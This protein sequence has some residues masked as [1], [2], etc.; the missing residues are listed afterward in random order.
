MLRQRMRARSFPVARV[1]ADTLVVVFALGLVWGGAMLV[2]LACKAA[3]GTIDS[4]SGYRTAY[5]YLASLQPS[6]ITP[7]TREVS[8]VAGA[9]AAVI[10]GCLA[11]RAIPRPYL[12]RGD[13]RLAADERGSVD[14]SPR[15]IER[16][17][18]SAALE[19][20][21]VTSARARYG[22]DDLTLDVAAAR[23]GGLGETLQDVQRRA[24]DSLARHEL[25]PLSVNVTL[26]RLDRKHRRELQ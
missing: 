12:A 25:P 2:A 6:D 10:F 8:A 26:V 17:V 15:A 19:H 5:R 4:L 13:L 7:A 23:A 3:P 21:A 20:A 9:V 11:W 24:R 18:E 14:V 16:A 22:T 1:L